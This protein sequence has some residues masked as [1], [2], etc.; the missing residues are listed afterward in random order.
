MSVIA[1]LQKSQQML[2]SPSGLGVQMADM[3]YMF[4]GCLHSFGPFEAFP[5]H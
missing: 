5:G 3:R 4:W 2:V 1:Y